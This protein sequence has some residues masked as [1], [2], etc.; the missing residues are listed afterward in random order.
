MKCDCVIN[1]IKERVAAI[2]PNGP[3]TVLG[4]FQLNVKAADGVHN[5]IV[6]LKNLTVTDGT[7]AAPDVT[8]N[9]GDEDFVAIG[10]K[11]LTADQAVADGK[12]QIIGDKALASSLI[13]KLAQ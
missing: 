11:T 8:L 13:S 12:V 4:V 3:R 10:S 6:D 2:D 9:I 5:I 1:K 7:A